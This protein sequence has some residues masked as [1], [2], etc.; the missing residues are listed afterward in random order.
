MPHDSP[1]KTIDDLK[2]KKIGVSSP[3]S[4]TEWLAKELAVKKG[5]GP[6]GITPVAIGNGVASTIAA[7]REHLV[8][9]DLGGTNQFLSMEEQKIGHPL[10][11]VSDYE[12]SMVSGLLVASN[13]I[14]KTNPEAV[15]AFVAGWV[16]T[17]DFI[18]T[19]RAETVKIESA[20]TQL[21][22]SVTAKEYDIT[23][24]NLFTKACNFDDQSIAELKRSLVG[25]KL[26]PESADM[27]KFYTTEFLPKDHDHR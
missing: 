17:V 12:A 20:I 5:W 4:L 1:I 25:L 15:R 10:V 26:L 2:G 24:D 27:S 16:E 6:E 13:H 11:S 8:D 23:H 22:E 19:H 3:G 9:A 7:F 18:R 21:P 14:I